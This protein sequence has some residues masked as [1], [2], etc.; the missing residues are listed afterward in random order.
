MGPQ[1]FRSREEWLEYIVWQLLDGTWKS[2]EVYEKTG[3]QEHD[4]D[5]ILREYQR[6]VRKYHPS[7]PES[8]FQFFKEVK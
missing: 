1:D 7:V 2:F 8:S 6:I 4:C 5:A 3:L